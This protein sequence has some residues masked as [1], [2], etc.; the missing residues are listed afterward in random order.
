MCK[1]Q[2]DSSLET[3]EAAGKAGA[4]AADPPSKEDSTLGRREERRFHE[5]PLRTICLYYSY[6][7]G[8]KMVSLERGQVD[9][10]VGMV[11]YKNF[12]LTRSSPYPNMVRSWARVS[13]VLSKADSCSSARDSEHFNAFVLL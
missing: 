12:A 10:Q 4:A 9:G 6:G 3:S 2:L 7:M 1:K 8:I 13:F 11:L 5:M